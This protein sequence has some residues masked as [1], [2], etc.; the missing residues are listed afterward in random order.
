[1]KWDSSS[2]AAAQA[3]VKK[4]AEKSPQYES[5]TQKQF[6]VWMKQMREKLESR[7]DEILAG[8]WGNGEAF[9][10]Y[11]SVLCRFSMAQQGNTL[12]EGVTNAA[13]IYGQMPAAKRLQTFD[14]WAAMGEHIKK[15]STGIDILVP[16]VAERNG[17]PVT[18]YNATKVFDVSQT[19][20]R[21]ENSPLYEVDDLDVIRS[22]SNSRLFD[23]LVRE[24]LPDGLE[25]A[26]I[27]KIN[28]LWVQD[29]LNAR[30]IRAALLR[31]TAHY[32]FSQA[33]EYE[34]SPQTNFEAYTS[35]YLV[36][37]YF[38]LDTGEDLMPLPKEA[39]P[40]TVKTG[41]EIRE[42]VSSALNTSMRMCETMEMTLEKLGTL[43]Y[44]QN[45][46]VSR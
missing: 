22:V 34:R 19:T 30:E 23:I 26:Y 4:A 13:L 35:A 24:D 1:M 17:Q 11:L 18:Y 33:S 28:E 37:T 43:L 8:A 12:G 21:Q 42:S 10:K 31:E 39:F 14:Q 46:E 3:Y 38:G 16:R 9:K 7:G 5:T 36:S 20:Y 40:T 45:E 29:G 6:G 25:A 41:V 27:P 2:Q 44:T 15:G 32:F